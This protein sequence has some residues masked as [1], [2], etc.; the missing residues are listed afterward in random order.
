MIKTCG[1]CGGTGDRFD[2]E[3]DDW[4]TPRQP[5]P[6]C[7]GVGELGAR[8]LQQRDPTELYDM[9]A[10]ITQ[11]V[12]NRE[13]ALALLYRAGS[14]RYVQAAIAVLM[15]EPDPGE[16]GGPAREMF[17]TRI[18]RMSSIGRPAEEP[19][20]A[21]HGSLLQQVAEQLG[22]NKSDEE[23]AE[24]L[25][26]PVAVVKSLVGRVMA[27]MRQEDSVVSGAHRVGM[28]GVA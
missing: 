15:R 19:V 2:D 20:A 28:R 12:L 9:G 22:L 11:L 8:T 26:Q 27:Q 24:T 6:S 25:D 4:A 10:R 5:C 1:A 3:L 18:E 16:K 13:Q 17:E 21:E 14:D 23:I 7:A